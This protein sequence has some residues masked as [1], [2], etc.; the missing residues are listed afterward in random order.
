MTPELQLYKEMM[1]D[2][3]KLLAS[4]QN[5]AEIAR[6]GCDPVVEVAKLKNIPGA[7]PE[8]SEKIIQFAQHMRRIAVRTNVD[9]QWLLDER[10]RTMADFTPDHRPLKIYAIYRAD[11]EMPAP[12]MAAQ[13]GH[14]YDGS[15][16][17]GKI[18]RPFITSQYK[19]TGHGTKVL[20][21]AKN[22]GQLI[23]AFHD[24]QDL[25]VPH[26][27]VIDRSHV[28]PPHFDGNPIVTALGI[29]PVYEDEVAHI[30]K[31]YTVAK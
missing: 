15:H 23:R 13:V 27:L 19:G 12:K 2:L 26:E 25:G 20:M 9:V 21:Y 17:N 28:L 10:K 8:L 16:D 5:G 1:D 30:T 7:T 3:K 18:V 11:L 6:P 31:R 4:V 24:A 14:A 29:G 22:L